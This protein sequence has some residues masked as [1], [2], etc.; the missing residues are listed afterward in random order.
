MNNRAI[1]SYDVRDIYIAQALRSLRPSGMESSTCL[2]VAALRTTASAIF[3]Q[4]SSSRTSNFAK[5]QPRG[6]P[7]FGPRRWLI[8]LETP[9]KSRR[10]R[11]KNKLM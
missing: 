10:F 7:N 4:N 8:P 5:A 11:P 3:S 1:R 2:A 9:P 6:V